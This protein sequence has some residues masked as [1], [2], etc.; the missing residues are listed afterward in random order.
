[1][2]TMEW[3]FPRFVRMESK[4]H[5]IQPSSYDYTIR[6]K[7]ETKRNGAISLDA[8]FY[9]IVRSPCIRGAVLRMSKKEEAFIDAARG[10]N[11]DS[12]RIY[13]AEH[14]NVD[15]R[16]VRTD[17]WSENIYTGDTGLMVAS[18]HRKIEVVKVL[19]EHGAD[20][21]ILNIYGQSSVLKSYESRKNHTSVLLQHGKAMNLQDP[22]GWTSLMVASGYWGS[23]D[24]LKVLLEHGADPNTQSLFGKTSLMKVFHGHN[25]H[26]IDMA[27]L[28]LQYGADPNIKDNFGNILL[29]YASYLDVRDYKNRKNYVRLLLEHGAD[30]NVQGNDGM[31]PLMIV[32]GKIDIVRVLLEHGADPNIQGK[33]RSS[34]PCEYGS[35]VLMYASEAGQNDVVRLL[36]EH[37]ADINVKSKNGTTA[38]LAACHRRNVMSNSYRGRTDIVRVLLEHG[39]DPN[40]QDTYGRTS[41]TYSLMEAI[42]EREGHLDIVRALLEHGADPN[43]QDTDGRTSLTNSLIRASTCTYGH[44]RTDIVR[45]L[46]EHGADP[47]IQDYDGT[48]VL[49]LVR[50][51]ATKSLTENQIRWNRRKAL[52]VV[53]TENGYFQSSSASSTAAA[54]LRYERVLG[55]ARLLRLIISYV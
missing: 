11:V 24:I 51:P 15:Y 22:D 2:E 17:D 7:N 43:I 39:A 4:F 27:R 38:L 48:T 18:R 42:T 6:K 32:V 13:V 53:L 37:G 31:T 30:P 33:D 26:M 9:V 40:V 47:N 52:I 23:I 5:G 50:N 49:S 16:T 28:L 34:I 54:L 1:M 19:L 3:N 45:L 55:N 36:L 20:S 29:I 12:V 46:L 8:L 21:N 25:C 44:S 41:L 10:G 14:G 35:T